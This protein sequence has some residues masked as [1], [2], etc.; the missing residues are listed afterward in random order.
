MKKSILLLTLVTFAISIAGMAAEEMTVT[1]KEVNPFTYFCI[2]H[3]GPFTEIEAVIGTLMQASQTQ[4]VFPGGPMIGVYYNSP[5]EVKPEELEWD[6]GFPVTPQAMVQSPLELKQW[7]FTTV[8]ACVHIGP[9]ETT[10]ET[11]TKM[12]EWMEANGY[13]PSGPVLERYMDM[14]PSKVKPE[15]LKTEVWIPCQKK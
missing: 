2:H 3:K 8:A 15:E 5:A 7:T 11:I 1:V 6:I 4:N 13:L 12:M 14:D 10:G 9:Y